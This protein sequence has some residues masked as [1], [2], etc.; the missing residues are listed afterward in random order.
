MRLQMDLFCTREKQNYD[1]HIV[2]ER[3]CKEGNLNQVRLV[4]LSQQGAKLTLIEFSQSWI[5]IM[6]V[7]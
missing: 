3:N 2:I 4:T 6:G 7:N 5:G 1:V